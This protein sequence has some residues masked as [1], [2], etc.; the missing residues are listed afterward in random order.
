VDLLIISALLLLSTVAPAA[1]GDTGVEI[2]VATAG[3][4]GRNVLVAPTAASLTVIVGATGLP[5]EGEFTVLLAVTKGNGQRFSLSTTL[6]TAVPLR[7]LM[8][9]IGPFPPGTMT[10]EARLPA[11]QITATC[12]VTAGDEVP[13]TETPTPS[14]TMPTATRTSTASPTATDTVT[15]T[16]TPSETST[17]AD[18][19]TE[20][21]TSTATET[22]TPQPLYGD[23]NCDDSLGAAD[24]SQQISLIAL[25]ERAVCGLDDADGDG[26]LT[27]ADVDVARGRLFGG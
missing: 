9:Q 20:T 11:F 21:A 24:L 2:D 1:A 18:T 15:P 10:V 22:A 26:E 3:G 6:S 25:S 19:V 4:C 17:P 14:P 16:P 13:P 7:T 8:L 23:A 12:S 27:A 5:E